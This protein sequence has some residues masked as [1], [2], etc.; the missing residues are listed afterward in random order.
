[1]QTSC[2]RLA[3][4][5][6]TRCC[7]SWLTGQPYR[8]EQQPF[9]PCRNFAREIW[10]RQFPSMLPS[11]FHF[12]EASRLDATGRLHFVPARPAASGFFR[13]ASGCSRRKSARGLAQSKTLREVR[14]LLEN[15]PASWTA[16]ALHR[17]RFK[18]QQIAVL[19]A[20]FEDED[21]NED[22]PASVF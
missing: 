11:S 2:K 22:D 3:C 19:R 10:R 18:V 4:Q 16:V 1:M 12:D 9:S 20:G 21:E 8:F 5:S 17:F 13:P 6:Q 15:A 7:A 14:R